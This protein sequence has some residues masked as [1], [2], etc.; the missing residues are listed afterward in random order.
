MRLGYLF[1][2][3]M[4]VSSSVGAAV[5]DLPE[6]QR[7]IGNVVYVFKASEGG[8]INSELEILSPKRAVLRQK[9]RAPWLLMETEPCVYESRAAPGVGFKIDFKKVTDE[10]TTRCRQHTC[11]LYVYG[12]GPA[13]CPI[14]A[15]TPAPCGLGLVL[16]PASETLIASLTYIQTH[17]CPAAVRPAAKPKF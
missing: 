2:A 14:G 10:Y 3:A 15:G 8:T 4:L 11:T 13:S 6:D 5:G 1:A 16:A 12:T 17:G 9:G 7:L